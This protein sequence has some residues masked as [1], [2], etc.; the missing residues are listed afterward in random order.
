[1]QTHYDVLGVSWK[2]NDDQIRAAFRRSV[3]ACHPDLHAGDRNAE[4]Q[5]RQVLAA[6]EILRRPQR[7]LIYDRLLRAERSARVQHIALTAFTGLVCCSVIAALT[8]W[9]P[10]LPD[11]SS[12]MAAVAAPPETVRV[13]VADVANVAVVDVADRVVRAE[14]NSSS[15][16]DRIASAPIR[17]A[18]SDDAQPAQRTAHN[19]RTANQRTADNARPPARRAEPRLARE[20]GQVRESDDPMA[21]AAFAARHP[22]ASESKLARSKLIGLIETA[23]D[24]AL[25]N[26]LGLGTG[27]IAERAQERL[28]RLHAA[29]NAGEDAAQT[30]SDNLNERAASFISARVTGWSSANGVSLASHANAYADEVVYNGSRKSKQAIVR[31]KRR[32]LELWPERS[33]EVRPDSVTVRCLASVCRVGG[34]VDWQTRNVARAM[35]VTGTSRFEFEVA[36]ARGSFRILSE[37]STELRRPRQ[38]ASC[39]SKGTDAKA[40]SKAAMSKTAMSRTI[41]DIHRDAA[42]CLQVASR[43][44]PAKLKTALLAQAHRLQRAQEQRTQAEQTLASTFAE[45]WTMREFNVR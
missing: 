45:R 32:L 43:T 7:R 15:K 38:V 42:H 19:Q 41:T 44:S 24:V 22:D 23:D 21:I 29:T 30:P 5:L 39:A 27:D 11:A 16:S 40:T 6:Y 18:I 20:W 3:K 36:F 26:I 17:Q 33:Y 31:E 14:V 9:L 25:L 4:R 8:M 34:L 1:M 12:L 37:S 28:S 10:R 13:A 35:L 2:S